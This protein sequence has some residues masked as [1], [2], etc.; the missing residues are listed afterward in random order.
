MECY[1]LSLRIPAYNG[2]V[3]YF[4]ALCEHKQFN[5]MPGTKTTMLKDELVSVYRK[6]HKHPIV[7]QTDFII[8]RTIAPFTFGLLFKHIDG[9]VFELHNAVMV[10]NV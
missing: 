9:V 1:G 7:I 5:V 6:P 2:I 3:H 4:I 8:E 10:A